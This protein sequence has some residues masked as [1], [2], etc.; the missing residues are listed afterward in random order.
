[1]IFSKRIQNVYRNGDKMTVLI[2]LTNTDTNDAMLNFPD[3]EIRIY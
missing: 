1:M 3:Q 2:G